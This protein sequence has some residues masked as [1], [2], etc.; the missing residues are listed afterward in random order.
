MNRIANAR[1]IESKGLE[2]RKFK[3][4]QPGEPKSLTGDYAWQD[5]AAIVLTNHNLSRLFAPTGSGKT[6]IIQAA[7]YARMKRGERCLIITP[8]QTILRGFRGAEDDEYDI[9]LVRKSGKVCTSHIQPFMSDGTAEASADSQSSVARLKKWLLKLHGIAIT[10]TSSFVL[11]WEE[12]TEE[13]REIVM[14]GLWVA[15]DEC[16]HM[17]VEEEAGFYTRLGKI[18]NELICKG[19][20]FTA[21]SATH[22]R[23]DGASLFS[24][25]VMAQFTEANTYERSFIDHWNFLGLESFDYQCIGYDD[26]K[27]MATVLKEVCQELTE[28]HIICVP[29][30]NTGFRAVDPAWVSGLINKLERRGLRVLD[31]VHSDTKDANKKQINNG[32]HNVIVS[33]NIMREGTDWVPA[34]RVHDMA[35]SKSTQRTVQTIGR[36]MRRQEDKKNIIYNAY[37]S[38]LGAG[39]D[40]DTDKEILRERVSDRVN[41]A[42]SGILIAQDIFSPVSIPCGKEGRSE[43]CTL[44]KIREPFGIDADTVLLV[45]ADIL[46]IAETKGED[47]E[48][49]QVR[50]ECKEQTLTATGF[51]GNE[52]AKNALE[53]YYHRVLPILKKKNERQKKESKRGQVSF[54]SP[55]ADQG[56]LDEL[57]SQF[58]RV[59]PWS[60]L[61]TANAQKPELK[62]LRGLLGKFKSGFMDM[63]GKQIGDLTV[64]ERGP[65]DSY[66]RPRWFCDCNCRAPNCRKSVLI[67]GG[68]LINRANRTCGCRLD[69]DLTGKQFGDLTVIKRGPN[70]D[71]DQYCW[72]CSCECGRKGC[73]QTVLIAGVSLKRGASKSCDCLH[74]LQDLVG[75]QF[76][77]LTVVKR[78]VNDKHS[79]PCWYCRCG[80]GKEGCRKT[81]LVQ[82]ARL[83][84]GKTVSCNCSRVV[85]LNL[86][87]R[88]VGYLTITKK[89][90]KGRG[91][92]WFCKCVCGKSVLVYEGHLKDGHTRSCGCL[93]QRWM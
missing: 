69:N 37:F 56:M 30:D 78:G 26:D 13:E 18:A 54:N 77:D 7:A 81:V 75:K 25:E 46:A 73:K 29:A 44:D 71:N 57:R 72:Y 52:E 93:R 68:N 62:Q 43:A 10:T 61:F 15:V 20:G 35:P 5:D 47:P 70:N 19:V 28:H 8:Q 22:F 1:I 79:Q 66:G 39:K 86:V 90:P 16:H 33:C 40:K 11:A 42:L 17:A 74:T 24:P 60:G 50:E 45:F 36:M 87:G 38:N 21:V 84:Q 85:K 14:R 64:V 80:C 49:E 82:G 32:Y 63:V 41:I 65:S 76:G 53:N 2:G 91:A 23:G 88:T 59:K 48:D 12:M 6:T 4:L 58:D 9:N 31:L 27:S 89:G 51:Y 55:I 92:R 3:P 67:T 83:R 34:S